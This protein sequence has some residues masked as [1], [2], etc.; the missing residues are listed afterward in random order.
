MV[1]ILDAKVVHMEIQN[2]AS[3][4][5][6]DR[7]PEFLSTLDERREHDC[8]LHIVNDYGGEA[9]LRTVSIENPT[10]PGDTVLAAPTY[11]E[12]FK[13]EYFNTSGG[14]ARLQVG[15]IKTKGWIIDNITRH[16]KIMEHQ[17]P[18]EMEPQGPG[19]PGS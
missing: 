18:E 13:Y 19:E 3:G 1:R 15:L 10:A 8:M 17:G 2:P 12:M 9:L 5:V 4:T 7:F 14:T 6:S 11:Q 16:I